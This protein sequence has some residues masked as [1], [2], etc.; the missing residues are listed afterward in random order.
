MHLPF[1]PVPPQFSRTTPGSPSFILGWD[2]TSRYQ[3]PR[4]VDTSHPATRLRR[5]AY[6]TL[7]PNFKTEEIAIRAVPKALL[8]KAD[9]P[10]PDP[11]YHYAPAVSWSEQSERLQKAKEVDGVDGKV[12]QMKIDSVDMSMACVVGKKA[13]HKN[14]T[15]RGKTTRRLKTAVSLVVSRGAYAY[16]KG[17]GDNPNA[18][19]LGFK[20]SASTD[21]YQWI[22]PGAFPTLLLP[23]GLDSRFLTSSDWTYIFTPT[24]SIYRMPYPELVGILRNA[25]GSMLNRIKR[26]EAQ[27]IDA[28][29]SLLP[30]VESTP[31]RKVYSFPVP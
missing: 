17:K 27:W 29:A 2:Q 3:R 12:E 20:D 24:L 30:S 7:F 23:A 18:L 16:I 11:P 8:T 21:P 1:I 13:V 31:A 26:T 22:S 9:F 28:D 25:F 14:A 19:Q 5:S 6:Y 15:I 4:F 10:W